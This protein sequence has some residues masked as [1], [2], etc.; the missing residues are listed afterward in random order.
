MEFADSP[1]SG[2]LVVDINNISKTF[3]DKNIVNNLSIKVTRGERIALVGPNGI[4][5]TICI[6]R[7]YV[8]HINELE[9]NKPER[10]CHFFKN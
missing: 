6:G 3:E 4:G 5:K 10:A 7:N 8:D 9:N 1:K 2:K